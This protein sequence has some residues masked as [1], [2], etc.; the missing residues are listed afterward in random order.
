MR[1]F[2]LSLTEACN[3][4]CSWCFW[5]ERDRQ[6][7]DAFDLDAIA[8]TMAARV[9]DGPTCGI[10]FYGGEPTLRMDRLQAVM[11]E[12][13]RR[14]P[15]RDWW[16]A[17]QTN[18]S[19]L[20]RIAPIADR[21]RILSVSVNEETLGS[22]DR[23]GLEALGSRLPVIARMTYVGE[24]L[25]P[26]LEGVLPFVSHVYWQLVNGASRPFDLERYERELE[27]MMALAAEH[28]DRIFVPLDYAWTRLQ[29]PTGAA[30]PDWF[31][32]GIG[33]DLVYV[34]PTGAVC[35][36]DELSLD[37]LEVDLEATR[38]EL[39]GICEGCP[40]LHA[41]RGRCPAVLVKHGREAF[42][43]YCRFSRLLFRKVAESGYPGRQ[44]DA[45]ALQTEVMH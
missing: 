16:F 25:A 30:E 19:Y 38:A 10:V 36:C 13:P 1:H 11:E 21:L 27:S 9:P 37:H 26:Q 2:Y 18:G 5:K 42:L 24:P 32:C 45:I 4:R 41:C 28:R 20:G 29:G 34:T 3:L 31:P 23:E 35:D 8:E 33:D 40:I 15:A 7:T 44:V 43:D 22:L 6:A 12:I 39:A 14:L 17:I